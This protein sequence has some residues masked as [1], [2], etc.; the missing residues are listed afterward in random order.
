MEI[1]QGAVF[2]LGVLV[3]VIFFGVSLANHFKEQKAYQ[4]QLQVYRNNGGQPY[5]S[6]RLWTRKDRTWEEQDDI[7]RQARGVA[8]L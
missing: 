2:L 3:V 8:G 5:V 1:L 6:K 7:N 4:G